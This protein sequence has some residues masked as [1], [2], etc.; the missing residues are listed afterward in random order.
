MVSQESATGKYTA[1]NTSALLSCAEG[2][3]LLKKSIDESNTPKAGKDKWRFNS[4]HLASLYFYRLLT[5]TS[6]ILISDEIWLTIRHFWYLECHLNIALFSAAMCGIISP[7]RPVNN[8]FICSC[9]NIHWYDGV[10]Y[11]AHSQH[12]GMIVLAHL[13]LPIKAM[14]VNGSD[15]SCRGILIW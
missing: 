3:Q 5:R 15:M 8:L 2:I 4:R 12:F 11:I 6:F 9:N 1:Y 7:W 10:L 13:F 14:E